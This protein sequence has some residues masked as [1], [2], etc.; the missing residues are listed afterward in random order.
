MKKILT[1]TLICLL[2]LSSTGFA[3]AA[4]VTND[5]SASQ[6]RATV[7][8]VY[9]V[10]GTY[11]SGGSKVENTIS[12]G[13]TKLT[14][15][16]CDA[17]FTENAYLCT[18]STGDKLPTPNS[19]RKDKDGNKYTFNGW[20]T[21]VDATVTYFDKVPAFTVTTFLYADWRADLSQRMDPIIPEG[22]EIV[23]P[24]HYLSITHADKTTEII[25][26]LKGATDQLNAEQLGYGY[27]V[28]L[29]K[30]GLELK[31]GDVI[32]VYT[33]GLG[34]GKVQIAPIGEH[35]SREINLEADINKGNYTSNYFTADKG[36]A[37]RTPTLTY[38]ASTAGRYNIYIKFFNG[39][40][41]MA[42]YMEPKQ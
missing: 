30:E 26:L 38:N 9:L 27:A 14:A 4:A 40:N 31:P 10:P 12:S 6:A 13:A 37:R 32:S 22:G 15:A 8:Q 18:L 19:Q 29:F 1:L 5:S 34:D 23:E 36:S 28:Q 24:N 42:V 3:I 2:L 7:P 41:I 25:A 21:I 20:W 33:T 35:T 11:M 17:I 16:E 39:G